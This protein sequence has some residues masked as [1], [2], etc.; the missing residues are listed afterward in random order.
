MMRLKREAC[1]QARAHLESALAADDK[2]GAQFTK[3][4]L[5]PHST[6]P[7]AK[8]IFAQIAPTDR[9]TRLR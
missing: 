2:L 9:G 1:A 7:P 5:A 4:D 3:Y 8:G 6:L